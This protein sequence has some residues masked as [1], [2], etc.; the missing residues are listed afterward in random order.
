MNSFAKVYIGKHFGRRK[1]AV[2]NS[3]VHYYSG[4]V[5]AQ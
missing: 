3:D 1:I 4:D 5:V 2:V